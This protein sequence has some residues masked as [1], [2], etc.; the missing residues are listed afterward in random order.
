MLPK[1][2]EN[3]VEAS[4]RKLLQISIPPVRYYLLT[5]V[6]GRSSNEPI[7]RKTL[8]ECSDY[9]LRK[10]LLQTLQPD[11]TWPLSR[12]RKQ[13]EERGPGPPIGWTYVMMLRNLFELGEYRASRGEGYI[14]ASL[15]RILSWQT[16]EGFIAGPTTDLFPLPQYNGYALRTLMNFGM[17][18]DSRV[19]SLIRWILRTQRSDGGWTIPYIQDVRYLPQ[20]RHMR[21]PVFMAKIRGGQVQAPNPESF[22]DIPSCIWTT[23]MVVRGLCQSYTLPE[24]PEVRRGL[25]L[26]LD[27]FFKRNY[28]S[29]FLK[30]DKNWTTLKYPTYSGSGLCALDILTW[31]GYGA[32]DPRMERPIKWLLSARS[33]DG[34]WNQSDR[35]HPYKDQWIT[36][37]SLSILN[38]YAQSLRGAPFGIRA[39]LLRS[40]GA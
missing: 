35:P 3:I 13:S 5:D 36:E 2:I 25:D 1:D 11:G 22:E 21:M 28:H 37:I 29:T 40:R 23:L 24:R 26:V 30:S 18:S 9:P 33:N 19:Q 38:R 27:C 32:D 17:E 10:R 6:M 4:S 15:E 20:Y 14:S 31:A 7:V 12:Q 39:E 16:K 8:E 34:F